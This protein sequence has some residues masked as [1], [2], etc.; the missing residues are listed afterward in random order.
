MREF[1]SFLARSWTVDAK[2]AARRDPVAEAVYS[3]LL[4]RS[5]GDLARRCSPRAGLPPRPCASARSCAPPVVQ[6]SHYSS[7]DRS[8]PSCWRPLS[9]SRSRADHLAT[10]WDRKWGRARYARAGILLRPGPLSRDRAR[11][12]RDAGAI[13]RH[14]GKDEMDGRS[15]RICLKGFFQWKWN[16][17]DLR[18]RIEFDRKRSYLLEKFIGYF[19]F[20]NLVNNCNKYWN[21]YHEGFRMKWKLV[22]NFEISIINSC[23]QCTYIYGSES[24]NNF[25]HTHDSIV[26]VIPYL[27]HSGIKIIELRFELKTRSLKISDIFWQIRRFFD[28]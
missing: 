21:I 18:S 17:R 25:L 3:R 4:A 23:V 14:R 15:P 8:V 24:R 22:G 13:F 27:F 11:F 9:L 7:T 2:S 28:R 1:R 12:L 5:L 26:I 16:V 6:P 20:L 19:S 10:V